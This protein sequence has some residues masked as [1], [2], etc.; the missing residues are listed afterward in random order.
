MG[1][2]HQVDPARVDDD[3]LC[4]RPQALFQAA[5]ENRVAIGRVRADHDHHVGMF[6]AVEI[7]RACRGAEGLAKAVA[8]GRM[9]DPRT[10]IG[11]VVQEHAARQFLHKEGFLVGAAAGGDDADGPAAIGFLQA[12]HLGGGEAQRLVPADLFPGLVN[13]VADHRVQ[14]AVLV[15]GIAIGK[16]T[17]HAG[18]TPIRLAVLVGHHAHQVVTVELRLEGTAHPAI[19]AGG[20][21]RAFGRAEFNNGFLL[22]GAR[23]AGLHAGAAADAIGRQEVITRGPGGHAAV[24]APAFDGQREG[25]LH[26]LAGAHAAAANDAF[27]RIVGEIGVRVVLGQ[28][29]GVGFARSVARLEMVGETTR[30]GGLVAH[31]AQADHAGHVL[32]F[33]IAIGR[34]G[35]AVERMVGDIKLHHPLADLL[36]LAGLG[37]NH[38]ALGHRRGT[39]GRRAP[40][41]LDL[42]H[43]E[44]AG[45]E[46]LKAVGGAKLGDLQP[47]F[48]GRAHDGGALGH[49]H[50]EP[51]DGQGDGLAFL[52]GGAEVAVGVPGDDQVFHARDSSAFFFA[53]IPRGVR[54]AAPPGWSTPKAAKPLVEKLIPRPPSGARNRLGNASARTSPERA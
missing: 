12:A 48:R 5:G 26:L 22:Q 10:G 29:F 51:I 8:R 7:L 1:R 2:F 30:F 32:Q 17:L 34:T 23:R 53:K 15:G 16:V 38:H 9:A 4:P 27:R 25:A 42:H 37:V 36:D 39:G 54:G 14:D 20:H 13:R 40:A 18:M 49:G 50:I 24:K 46:S 21:D 47:R 33:A 28:P 11:I 44:A 45:P 52:G 19:G 31:V 43:A 6:D 3:Q 35:Q 41:A